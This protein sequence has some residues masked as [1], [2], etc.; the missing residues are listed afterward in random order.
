MAEGDS[1][2]IARLR[3]RVALREA[4][5]A[6]GLTQLQV[7]EEMEWSNSKVI[8]IEKGDVTVSINDLRGLLGLLGVRD[9]TKINS[10]LADARI[11]RTRQKPESVWWQEGRFRDQMSESFRKFVEYEAE[12]SQ[13]RSFNIFYIPGPLQTPEYGTALTGTWMDE[14]DFSQDKVDALVEARA[15]RREALINRGDA[16]EYLV[17]LDQ[18]VL[19]RSFGGRTAFVEQLRLLIELSKSGLYKLRMLPFSL[20]IAIAN[21]GSFELATVGGA[22]ENNQ[23]MYRENGVTDEIVETR[24]DTARHRKR[25]D[26]L[27]KAADNEGDTT[28]YVQKR[29]DELEANPHDVKS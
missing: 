21:N 17:L 7:A 8:R 22:R 12:A 9:K 3:V 5:E 15:H 29:I 14:A 18:S 19:L 4:R 28:A 6:A 24:A 23:V 13:L 25:F 10:L 26:Q 20:E 11:A 16:L 2:T 27:W 1:P